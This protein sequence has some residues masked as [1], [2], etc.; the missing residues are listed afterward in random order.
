L[1]KNVPKPD[2][3]HDGKA[4]TLL[5]KISILDHVGVLLG[6]NWFDFFE[7][8]FVFFSSVTY[9]VCEQQFSCWRV[10]DAKISVLLG[11]F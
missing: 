9:K 7:L 8:C 10:K 3:A 5:E 1:Q 2:F 6:V 11:F 4:A